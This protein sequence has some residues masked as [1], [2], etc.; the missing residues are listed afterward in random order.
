MIR[1]I[2][3]LAGAVGAVLTVLDIHA[4]G[5]GPLTLLFLL[6]LPAVA[7]IGLIRGLDLAARLVVAG[8]VSLVVLGGVAEVML[9]T[10]SWSPQGGVVAVGAVSAVLYGVDLLV[11]R[12]E[13]VVPAPPLDDGDDE[14]A[15]ESPE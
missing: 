5:V 13:P 7:V 9:A 4:P 2:P 10:S 12:P 8:T 6:Y 11:N 15:F 3:A 1:W 14:W